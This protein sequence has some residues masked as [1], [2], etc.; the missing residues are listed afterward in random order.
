ML[1]CSHSLGITILEFSVHF[2]AFDDNLHKPFGVC[3]NN[4]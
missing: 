2:Q 3:H 4:S 1:E